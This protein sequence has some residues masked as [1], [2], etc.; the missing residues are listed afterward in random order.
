MIN[1]L[2]RNPF[3]AIP[4]GSTQHSRNSKRKILMSDT[5]CLYAIRN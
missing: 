2:V 4:T 1:Q 3:T 5:L